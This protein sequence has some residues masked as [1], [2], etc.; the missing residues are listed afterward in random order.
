MIE[1]RFLQA[2]PCF[3]VRD[4]DALIRFYCEAMAF[5][6]RYKTQVYAVLYWDDVQLHIYPQ[7]D[8]K[9]AGQGSAYFFV[10]GVDAVYETCKAGAKI[11]HP[12]KNQEYCLRDFLMEDP[13]GNRVGIAQRVRT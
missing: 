12:I 13:E 11:I 8:G 3:A 5:E 4:F 10:M 7:R 1:P 2:A 6:A 9:V